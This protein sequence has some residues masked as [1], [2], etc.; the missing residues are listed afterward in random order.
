MNDPYQLGRFVDAQDLNGTYETAVSE[1][2]AGRKVSHWMWFVFPQVAGLG[3][4]SMSR[5]FAISSL[6]EAQAYLRHPVLGARLTECAQILDGL[7]GKSA[8]DIFGSVDAMKLHSSMTLFM[9]AAP[10]EPVF[11]SVLAKY[12]GGSPD[13]NTIA[14]L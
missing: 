1:L 14:R 2:R 10:D 7:E 5:R 4:S 12:F 8:A 11:A 6:A 9:T 3:Y 13:E